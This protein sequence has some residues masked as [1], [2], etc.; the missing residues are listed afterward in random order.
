MDTFGRTRTPGQHK[1][2]PMIPTIPRPL[3]L[4]LLA[5]LIAHVC[6][7]IA[8]INGLVQ[9]DAISY[10]TIANNLLNG[11]GYVF[12]PGDT[13]TAWRA[14]GY[15]VLLYVVWELFWE[16]E[17]IARLANA[18]LW[19]ST[20]YIT[21][22]YS[23]RTIGKEYAVVASLSVGLY[24][25]FL[26]MSG[27]LWSESLF[28]FLFMLFHLLFWKLNRDS[29]IVSLLLCGVVLGFSILTKSTAVVMFPV[30]VAFSLL[31]NSHVSFKQAT[32]IAI[33]GV[34]VMGCWTARNY[35]LHDHLILVESN[36]GYNLYVG[37][38]PDTPIP[39]A[40]QKMDTAR[41]DARYRELVAQANYAEA[42]EDN[43]LKQEAFTQM[44]EN[45]GRTLALSIGKLFDF[46]LPDFFIAMNARSGSYGEFY[47]SLWPV[48]LAVT[49]SSFL[50]V[51]ILALRYVWSH[52]KEAHV[53]YTV[54]VVATYT[55]PHMLVY[56]ASRYHMP[57]MPLIIVL[58]TPMLCQIAGR[59]TQGSFFRSQFGN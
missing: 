24:P 13:P 31:K 22:L 3:I 21:Y 1:I 58:A 52:R 53:L 27:L 11:N 18:L 20:S 8:S 39:F 38:R 36:M 43:L 34:L 51:S 6:V 47:R 37:S 12:N 14:P 49:M 44:R 29:R 41:Q 56:G 17:T 42:E 10:V 45:P 33:V 46:W 7:A 5:V 19:M 35:Y 16:S 23:V 30:I 55:M 48:I 4:V 25:T 40:W 54:L 32:L 57:L 28:I 59:R 50:I 9:D 15:P 2:S 26:G